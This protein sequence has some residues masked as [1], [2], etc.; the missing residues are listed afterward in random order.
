[1]VTL[2]NRQQLRKA[3]HGPTVVRPEAVRTMVPR[4]HLRHLL[5]TRPGAVLGGAVGLVVLLVVLALS[6]GSALS[7]PEAHDPVSMTPARA[8]VAPQPVRAGAAHPVVPKPGRIPTTRP[9][10][11]RIPVENATGKAYQNGM[12]MARRMAGGNPWSGMVP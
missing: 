1:V 2:K 4:D 12:D 10:P 7:A 9:S 5:S 3:G 8:V 6:A 11:K